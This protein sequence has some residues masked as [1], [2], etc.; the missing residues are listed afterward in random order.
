MGLIQNTAGDGDDPQ[1]SGPCN[2]IVRRGVKVDTR[3]RLQSGASTTVAMPPRS[4]DDFQI[5]GCRLEG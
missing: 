4:I 5:F 2:N 1:E 3:E